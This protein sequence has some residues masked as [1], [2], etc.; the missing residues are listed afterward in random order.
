MRKPSTDVVTNLWDVKRTAAINSDT[1]NILLNLVYGVNDPE[2]KVSLK[3]IK[4]THPPPT[5][6]KTLKITWEVS[7]MKRKAKEIG[8]NFEKQETCWKGK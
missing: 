5:W 1:E 4:I 6:L 8:K 3:Y 7:L 2:K